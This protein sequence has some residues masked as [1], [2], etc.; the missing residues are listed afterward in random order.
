MFKTIIFISLIISFLTIQNLYG[1]KYPYLN[2][3]LTVE[4]RVNDLLQRMTLEEK[5][6][7]MFKAVL[8][9]L[10]EDE[11]GNITEESLDSLFKGKSVGALDPVR[12]N[13]KDIAKYSEAADRYLRT[14][15][16]LGIPAIQ[17]ELGGIHGQLA[18]DATIFPQTIGQGCTWN[19]ELI[20]KMAETIAFEASKTGCDQFFAPVFD[21]IRDPRYGRVEE[22]FGEDPYLVSEMGKAFVIGMQ[23]DPKITKNKIPENHLISTAKHFVGYSMPSGGLN[24]SPVE[25]G[26]RD[27]RSLFLYPFEKAV[28]EA[29]VYSI[30]PS[31]SAVNGIP[32]H[33]NKYLLKDVLRKEFGFKGYVFADYGAVGMLQ[34]RHHVTA[35][36]IE[37]AIVA[38]R[39][40]VDL[41]GSNFAYST[42]IETA[43]N[44]KELQK[45]IDESV[46]NILTVKFKIG[47]FDKPYVVPK[48]L[49]KLVHRKESVRLAR[50]VAEESIVLLKNKD[51]L[52]PLK[53]SALK[54]IAV[55]GPNA[56]QVEY[57]D[58]S[59]P[60]NNNT[61]VTI[62]EGIKNLTKGKV[63]INYAKGCAITDLD[64]SGIKEAV[65]VA[66][67]SDV[68]VLV[69]GGTSK[70]LSGVGW[71]ELAKEG[72]YPTCGEGFD[73]TELTPPGIQPELIRAIYKTG[74]PIV[75]IMV[76]GRPYSI[77]WE[78]ENIPAILDAWYPGEEGGNAVARIL[79]GKVVPSGKLTVSV[80]QSVG[81]VPVFYNYKPIGRGYYHKPG[82]KKMPGHDYVFSSPEPLFPFGFGLSYT[83]FKYSDLKLKKNLIKDTDTLKFSV[84]VKNIGT[85]TGKE[86]IQVYINDIYSSV[87]TPVKVLKGF[88][89]VEISPE[90][91]VTVNFEIPG[92]ELGL[93]NKDMKYVV[94]RGK[95]EL[96]IGA[97]A[98]D[99]RLNKTF[100]VINKKKN[101]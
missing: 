39:A 96:M 25:I 30:M 74:K 15:T 52:L 77:K 34:R 101:K 82:T 31:Y 85:L 38:L 72:A 33:A 23:G 73:R 7:Q 45:L 90:K 16:R 83:K 26:P 97:S 91:T 63:K 41:E 3:K 42:F 5:V 18:S 50:Q 100:Y 93:W 32:V 21:I 19:P 89:K 11:N 9:K 17:V 62:L 10:K 44:N 49:S 92:K 43:K 29:N 6:N 70:S 61:G 86:V 37:T 55:I 27:L 57:G 1:Q 28:K 76:H 94:E 59:P 67:K 71:G 60:K 46:K 98:E 12:T 78:K 36:R 35:N 22:C 20:K 99:I 64:D 14:H 66:K 24:I 8:T 68:V 4:E 53:L 54:S 69:I 87:V 79:F 47:L 80:P 58:Y 40:G 65:D 81:H 2:S 48:N 56:N 51:N 13:V 95:F 84:K 75:L 88:K